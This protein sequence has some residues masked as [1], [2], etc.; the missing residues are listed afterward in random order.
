M[1][2]PSPV[3]PTWQT[4]E[5]NGKPATKSSKRKK[6]PRKFKTEA[7]R[8]EDDKRRKA[9]AARFKK[10]KSNVFLLASVVTVIKTGDQLSDSRKT[11]MD[12]HS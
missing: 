8:I 2:E 9:L 12:I 5:K 3:A 6:P 7:E 4:P 11:L 1:P 10:K